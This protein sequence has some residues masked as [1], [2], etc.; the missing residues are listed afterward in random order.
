MQKKAG[1]GVVLTKTLCCIPKVKKDNRSKLSKMQKKTVGVELATKNLCSF[2][3]AKKGNRSKLS[4][5]QKKAGVGVVLTKTRLNLFTASFLAGSHREPA[6]FCFITKILSVCR[7]F[8]S[9]RNFC[10]VPRSYAALKKCL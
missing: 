9:F 8:F 7:Y 10:E 1:V 5:R 6:F 3:K 4:K 2:P